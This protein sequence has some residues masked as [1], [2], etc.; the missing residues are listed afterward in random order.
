MATLTLAKKAQK[1]APAGKAAKTTEDSASKAEGPTKKVAP[2]D[3]TGTIL[4]QSDLVIYSA[5]RKGLPKP[6]VTKALGAIVE[7]IA[8]TLSNGGEIRLPG[9]GRFF[10]KNIPPRRAFDIK[11]KTMADLPAMRRAAFKVSKNIKSRLK[12]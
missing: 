6:V 1:A 4:Y 2:Q 8:E 9:L 7:A 10:I 5:V 3:S 12:K 11:S